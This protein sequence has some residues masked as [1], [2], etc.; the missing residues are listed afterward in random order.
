M[1][2]C[3]S[4][5][6]GIFV[7][8]WDKASDDGLPKVTISYIGADWTIAKF[9]AQTEIASG[10]VMVKC[11]KVEDPDMLNDASN[12]GEWETIQDAFKDPIKEE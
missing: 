7:I 8:E 6:Y 3:A 4:D 5:D 11:K 10:I 9:I 2:T 12:I 1:N